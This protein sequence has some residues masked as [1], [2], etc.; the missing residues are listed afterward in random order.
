MTVWSLNSR[1][2]LIILISGIFTGHAA[3]E[4]YAEAFESVNALDKLESFLSTFGQNFYNIPKNT[5]KIILRK[6]SWIVPTEYSFGSSTVRPLRA[7]ENI[8]WKLSEKVWL[9]IHDISQV[10]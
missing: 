3:I 8:L 10:V 2:H 9:F 1:L 6:E 7:G 4:L 5:R